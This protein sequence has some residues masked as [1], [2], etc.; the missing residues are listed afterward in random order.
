MLNI[1]PGVLDGILLEFHWMHSLGNP[2]SQVSSWR[3]VPQGWV[4]EC[5][6]SVPL[7]HGLLLVAG[8][9]PS[10]LSKSMF[11]LILPW[12]PSSGECPCGF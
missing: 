6:Y 10:V 8:S 9:K 5:F 2:G 4:C 12:V 1:V 7:L 3:I 11:Q